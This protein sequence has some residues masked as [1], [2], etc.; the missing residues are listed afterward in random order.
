ME[1]DYGELNM[2]ISSSMEKLFRE[3]FNIEVE[4]LQGN[5]EVTPNGM[6]KYELKIY[7]EQKSQLIKEFILQMISMPDR[8][9]FN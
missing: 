1:K 5:R 3:T 8:M 6:I 7:D 2:E 9:N 4:M